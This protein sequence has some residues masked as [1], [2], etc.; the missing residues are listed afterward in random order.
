MLP[1]VHV[2][3]GRAIGASSSR[4]QGEDVNSFTAL[5]KHPRANKAFMCGVHFG[6]QRAV[7]WLEII[8]AALELSKAAGHYAY[9]KAEEPQLQD[10]PQLAQRLRVIKEQLISRAWTWF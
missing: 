2:H 4:G 1:G 7:Q 10:V 6:A 3:E 5:R 9:E 8:W